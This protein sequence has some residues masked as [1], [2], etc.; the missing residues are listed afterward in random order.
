MVWIHIPTWFQIDFQTSVYCSPAA[1][2]NHLIF[3]VVARDKN[4]ELTVSKEELISHYHGE[5]VGALKQF[6]YM[7]SPPSLL[8]LNVELL[9]HGAIEAVI[10]IVYTPFLFMD[11]SKM[12]IDDLVT[13]DHDRAMKMRL[14]YYQNPKC[15]EM[16]KKRLK[17]CV[18]KGFFEW[19]MS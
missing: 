16:I 12:L 11:W 17:N 3:A 15:Q 9:R 14:K 19:L 13:T 8:D 2:I 4:Y 5:F 6:G 7:K 18:M 10:D 1:D